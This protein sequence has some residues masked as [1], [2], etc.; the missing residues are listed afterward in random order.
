MKRV[1]CRR[2]FAFNF[3]SFAVA[4]GAFQLSQGLSAAPCS[5]VL[6]AVATDLNEADALKILRSSVG[7][8]AI[9]FTPRGAA[10]GTEL[11]LQRPALK[12]GEAPAFLAGRANVRVV[13]YYL[14]FVSALQ[15][16]PQRLTSFAKFAQ[17]P[18]L[19]REARIPVWATD[20]ENNMDGPVE[21][22]QY[23]DLEPFA[24]EEGE[25]LSDLNTRII[26]KIESQ[27]EAFQELENAFFNTSSRNQDLWLRR[28]AQFM[29]LHTSIMRMAHEAL[30]K[31]EKDSTDYMDM[32]T[33]LTRM[34]VYDSQT[35]AKLRE[36]LPMRG[37][38]QVEVFNKTHSEWLAAI[39]KLDPYFQ[40]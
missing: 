39:T 22:Q 38:N 6:A 5:A 32:T 8:K 36:L 1:N 33:F 4:F 9:W 31:F 25:L 27:L 7:F 20:S 2:K 26:A 30:Q 29:H 12:N 37:N 13:D 16:Q 23:K 34:R 24:K 18:E 19:E 3:L 35:F 15:K 17:S 14:D 28:G 10:L 11:G 40:K 21:V